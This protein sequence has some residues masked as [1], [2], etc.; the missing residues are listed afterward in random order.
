M[1]EGQLW[2]KVCFLSPNGVLARTFTLNKRIIIRDLKGIVCKTWK[3]VDCQLLSVQPF[4]YVADLEDKADFQ[5]VLAP[6]NL[7]KWA[8]ICT[9]ESAECNFDPWVLSFIFQQ[10]CTNMVR[11]QSELDF[12]LFSILCMKKG[13]ARSK[14]SCPK[15]HFKLGFENYFFF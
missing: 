5:L 9:A 7:K 8:Q 13:F 10:F 1:V 4:V 15:M 12:Y 3:L 6:K 2:S 14:C 11:M